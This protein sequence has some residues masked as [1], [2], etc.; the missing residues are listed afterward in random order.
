VLLYQSKKPIMSSDPRSNLEAARATYQKITDN[1]AKIMRGQS[2]ASRQMLA[3]LAAGGHVLL[4]DFPGTGKTTLAKALAKTIEAGFKRLQFTPDL[5]PSDILGVSIFDQRDQHFHFHEGP[6]FTNILL[7][8]EINR[9]SPRTQSALLEAMGE[10]QV[11]VEGERRDLPELFFVIAT[12]NPVEF[13]GTYPLP[14]AQMDRF[15]MQFTLGYVP[16]EEEVAILTAQEHNHPIDELKPVVT[17]AEVMGL[18][19]AVEKIR[20]SEE[21]KRYIVDIVAAT[22]TAGGVQLGASPRASIALMKTAQAIALFD[23][24]DF[25]GPEQIQKLAVPVVAHRL[26]LEPQARFSGLTTRSVVGD[27]LKKVRVPA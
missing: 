11:S 19:R 18:K 9:A 1:I 2:M 14:E 27:I 7:A 23:G 21:L 10:S 6:V 3:A 20:I 17:L 16:P 4:E 26:V 24:L 8:D 25:V 15:A 5:L 22:R 13:R 12:E